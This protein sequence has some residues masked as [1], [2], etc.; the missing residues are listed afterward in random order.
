MSKKGDILMVETRFNNKVE[1]SY[2]FR[3][4]IDEVHKPDRRDWDIHCDSNEVMIEE[5]WKIVIKNESSELIKNVAKDLQD[6]FFTS[7]NVSVL[8]VKVEDLSAFV[9]EDK[10]Y[11]ILATK[12]DMG[13]I[14]DDLSKSG[15]YRLICKEEKLIICGNDERGTAHGSYFLEDIMNIKEAPIIKHQDIVRKPVFSPRIIHSGWGEY[16]YPNTHLST[17]AHYGMD[18]IVLPVTDID[19]TST[20]YQDINDTIER[21]LSNGI[22]VYLY[23][24]IS[25]TKHPD[26][27]DAEEYYENIY[28]AFFDR[29]PLAKGIVLVGESV[30]FPSKDNRTTGKRYNVLDES[31]LPATKPSPGWWPCYDY[32]QFVNMI[33]NVIRKHKS[34]ADIVFWTYNWGWAPEEER[35]ALIKALPDDITVMVTFEMFEQIQS[36][37]ITNVCVDYTIA[38]EGPGKYFTSEAKAIHERNI[39]LYAMS[40]TAGLTWDF[41]VI[42]Y[43][44]VPFQWVRRYD[45]LLKANKEYNL[46]GLVESHHYGWWPSFVCEMTKWA[47][48]EPRIESKEIAFI[49]ACRDYGEKAAHTVIKCWE[50]WSDAIRHY[51]PTNEDQYGPFRIGP[52]YPLIFH[53][54][55]SKAFIDKRLKLPASWHSHSSNEIFFTFYEPFEDPRQSP[56]SSRINVEIESLQKMLALWQ[57]GINFIEEALTETSEKKRYI[58][59]RLLNL[60][61]FILNCISTTIHVKQWWKLNM[62]LR[63]ETDY[64]KSNRI[65]DKLIKIAEE[66]VVN[67]EKTIPLV[68]ADSRLGWEPSMDYTTDAEKLKWKIEQVRRVI[69][70]EIPLYRSCLT[71]NGK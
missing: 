17:I 30:E 27:A 11:I 60:G 20:G 57:S 43:E 55:L 66:E 38:F 48:W 22:D 8:L 61:K 15:S 56:V 58:G 67:A 71:L 29:Y 6:Y 5:G 2:Q 34:D 49:I 36:E 33:K 62:Q 63:I 52:S 3:Q 46:T 19:R 64:E 44:P 26:D 23:S 69:S 16:Q 42:P 24:L 53:P 28:G 51:I 31:D 39:R 7:M 10:K 70:D 32:P 13:I 21:A 41:G 18:A 59:E 12:E 9:N 25:S 40:N 35:I 65:L 54:N 50:K 45:A 14:G 1:R 4:Y 47:F 68:E 37:N